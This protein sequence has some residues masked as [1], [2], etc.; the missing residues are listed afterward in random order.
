MAARIRHALF[1]LES[2]T[3]STPPHRRQSAM[4]RPRGSKLPT[5]AGDGKES[6]REKTDHVKDARGVRIDRLASYVTPVSERNDTR[7]LVDE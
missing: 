2:E 3:A 7:G 1:A 6:A 4:V 5:H